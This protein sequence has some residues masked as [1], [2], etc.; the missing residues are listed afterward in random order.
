MGPER[1]GAAEGWWRIT[2]AEL[3]D[4]RSCEYLGIALRERGEE[5]EAGRWLRQGAERGDAA[6]ARELAA[7]GILRM[8]RETDP[9]KRAV[10]AQEAL[11][12]TR[13]AA[14]GGDQRARVMLNSLDAGS[15]S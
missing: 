10:A 4:D 9:A 1:A 7:L 8:E 6:C 5:E 3:S 13:R 11:Q 2:A 12:W 14:L 15:E